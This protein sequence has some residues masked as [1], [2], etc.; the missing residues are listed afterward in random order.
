M[1]EHEDEK[2]VVGTSDGYVHKFTDASEYTNAFDSNDRPTYLSV[3]DTDDEKIKVFNVAN[4]VWYSWE[5]KAG[6]EYL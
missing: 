1:S 5:D 2:F 3:I 4:V 6:V